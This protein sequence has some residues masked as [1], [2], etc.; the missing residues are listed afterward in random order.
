MKYK[1]LAEDLGRI[2]F[3]L[4]RLV[5]VNETM[6]VEGNFAFLSN[7]QQQVLSL[8]SKNFSNKD[9]GIELHIAESTVR[10]HLHTICRV[11]GVHG[12]ASLRRF[13]YEKGHTV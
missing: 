5:G 9:M 11:L 4:E 10:N 3:L 8:F 6:P 1:E 2:T 7:R 12:Q 13:L